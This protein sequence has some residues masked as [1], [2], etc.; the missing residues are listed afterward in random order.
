MPRKGSKLKS[1]TGHASHTRQLRSN[2]ASFVPVESTSKL[3]DTSNHPQSPTLIFPT[4]SVEL[5]QSSHKSPVPESSSG[6]ADIMSL[7]PL[8]PA[9]GSK[10][11]HDKDSITLLETLRSQN[12]IQNRELR[13]FIAE[14]LSEN[15]TKLRVEL[16]SDLNDIIEN[17]KK[18]WASFKG[19]IDQ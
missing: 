12:E 17:Q 5:Q 6:T 3:S 9:V 13:A 16:R 11:S 14:T 1:H 15:A 19:E 10:L 7:D 18:E 2:T 4:P 8:P